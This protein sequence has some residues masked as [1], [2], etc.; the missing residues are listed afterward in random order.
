RRAAESPPTRCRW[1]L[2][3]EERLGGSVLD[4]VIPML[5]IPGRARSASWNHVLGVCR[6][7]HTV[8]AVLT[9]PGGTGAET[10]YG[11][12]RI[13]IRNAHVPM[14][15]VARRTRSVTS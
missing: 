11:G 5:R 2:G 6:V 4:A 14:L 9:P 8:V 7:S 13:R 15:R 1:C 3:R 12:F 10:R